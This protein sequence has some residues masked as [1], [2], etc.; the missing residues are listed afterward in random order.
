MRFLDLGNGRMRDRLRPPRG[1]VMRATFGP[2]GRTAVTAGEDN[3]VI[4]WDARRGAITETLDGHA[5]QT[6]S[7]AI[8][9][10]GRTL[11]TGA[12]DGKVLIW[13]LGGE[14]RLDRPFRIGPPGRPRLSPCRYARAHRAVR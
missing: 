13:D 5:G 12:L 3:R 8:S 7:L 9:R 1:S 11:Y 2:D 6:T 10:D 4:V 14:R